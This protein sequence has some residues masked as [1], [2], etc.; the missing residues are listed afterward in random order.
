MYLDCVQNALLWVGRHAL[1]T[2]AC[3][4]ALALRYLDQLHASGTQPL[5]CHRVAALFSFS[6]ALSW[7]FCG[8]DCASWL[9]STKLY[10]QDVAYPEK[11]A[12]FGIPALL[13]QTAYL[14]VFRFSCCETLQ[15]LQAVIPCR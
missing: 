9:H 4:A 5:S 6:R 3:A 15:H 7:S 13:E 11:A 8:A 2:A 10:L 1:E 12:L 14:I